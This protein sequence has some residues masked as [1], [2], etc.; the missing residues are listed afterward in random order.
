MRTYNYLANQLPR[1]LIE[2]YNDME[3]DILRIMTKGIKNATKPDIV[4]TQIVNKVSEYD[5]KIDKVIAIIFA[6]SEKKAVKDGV[7][8]VEEGDTAVTQYEAN[9]IINP[10]LNKALTKATAISK[11]IRKNAIDKYNI[12]YIYL[13]SGVSSIDKLKEIYN[14]LARSGLTIYQSAG[15]G[16]SRSYSVENILRRE[17]MYEVNQSN[18]KVNMEN[19]EK[20]SAKFIEVSSHPTARTASKYMKHDYEDHSSWQGQV[21]YS[22]EMIAGYKEFE[23]TCGYGEL[24]GICGI[25]CYHQFSMNYTGESSA[26]QYSE[27]EVQRNY[28]LSQI[29]REMERG[30]RQLKQEYAVFQEAGEEITANA[31][32][33]EIRNRRSELKAFCEDNGLKYYAW[34]TEV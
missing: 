3:M 12:N 14:G 1:E 6:D 26:T 29:Q 28:E 22:G 2:V 10:D 5:S 8:L 18:A 7:N 30:I 13:K 16:K 20:S 19:F 23:S 31:I 32:N 9:S 4:Q 27:K 25:N 24:L 11:Q 34:R 15:G 33:R 17:I 21:Y